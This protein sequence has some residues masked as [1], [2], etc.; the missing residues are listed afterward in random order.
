MKL[1]PNPATENLTVEL[2]S[3]IGSKLDGL[4]VYTVDGRKVFGKSIKKQ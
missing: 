3:N 1:Y 4:E 2:F